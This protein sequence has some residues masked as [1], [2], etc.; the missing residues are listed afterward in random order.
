MKVG[1]GSTFQLALS[2]TVNVSVAGGIPFQ[3]RHTAMVTAQVAGIFSVPPA[4]AGYWHGKDF[5]TLNLAEEGAPP[6]HQYTLLTPDN[7]LLS[8][9][10]QLRSRYHTDAIG[11]LPSDVT[12]T[13]S[14]IWYYHLDTTNLNI[15]NLDTLIR[16]L[17]TIQ[18]TTDSLY[19]E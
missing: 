19:G 11:T 12:N 4:S 16:Q 18:S 8:L 14:L 6:L 5:K 1:V 17:N 15:N 3:Q 13:F 7:A 2:Y 9:F 10:D